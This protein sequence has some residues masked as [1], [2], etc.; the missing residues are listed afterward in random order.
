MIPFATKP[1]LNECGRALC[2]AAFRSKTFVSQRGKIAH[3]DI[4]NQAEATEPWIL[5]KGRVRNYVGKIFKEPRIHL[6][7][8]GAP[9]VD[10]VTSPTF[11]FEEP[12]LPSLLLATTILTACADYWNGLLPEIDRF[13]FSHLRPLGEYDLAWIAILT[14]RT[15]A[16]RLNE[17]AYSFTHFLM[18]V[19]SLVGIYIHTR[20]PLSPP[21]EWN[22]FG[23]G[24]NL[25]ARAIDWTL[26]GI[27]LRR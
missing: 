9:S 5:K 3:D 19:A 8:G 22:I 12:C 23:A 10:M 20:S 24:R 7:E 18:K 15:S 13:R 16:F 14:N 6:R 26:S 11:V 21:D 4:R 1:S 27:Y 2:A 25:L 17:T